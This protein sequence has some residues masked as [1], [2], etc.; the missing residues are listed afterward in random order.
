M[1]N[2]EKFEK[3]KPTGVQVFGGDGSFIERLRTNEYVTSIIVDEVG[4][5]LYGREFLH[6][7]AYK[8]RL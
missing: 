8:Y 3:T 7:H 4:E 2:E 6:G 1:G 5:H